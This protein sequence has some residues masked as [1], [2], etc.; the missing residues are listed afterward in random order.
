[1]VESETRPRIHQRLRARGC[2][3]ARM[4]VPKWLKMVLSPLLHI[5]VHYRFV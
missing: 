2:S 5:M 4:A 1:M 3:G